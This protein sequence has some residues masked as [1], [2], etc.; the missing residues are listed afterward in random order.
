M[1]G[2]K[3]R[4]PKVAV[5]IPAFREEAHI[6]AVVRAVR[7]EGFDP[8]VVDDGSDDRTAEVAGEAGAAVIRHDRNQGKGVALNHGFDYARAHGYEA[9]VTLDADGQHRPDEIRRFVD[10]YA[11]TGVPV[12]VG[13]RMADTKTMPLI[14]RWTNRFMSWWLSR[15]MGQRVPDTQCGF[16][17]YRLDAIPPLEAGSERFAAESEILL[18]IARRGTRIGAVPISTVYGNER[19]KVNPLSDTVRFL[20][21]LRRFK[22]GNAQ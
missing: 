9:A 18:L 6:G 19:S 14:R 2:G 11:A 15:L 1:S 20:R 17:L 12:L 10:A 13:T 5:I 7:S 8:V 3:P 22:R 21:M 4:Q 16:R